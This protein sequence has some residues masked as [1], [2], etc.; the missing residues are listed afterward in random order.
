MIANVNRPKG[1]SPLKPQA[2]NPMRQD[3][4]GR[5]KLT[6]ENISIL[7]GMAGKVE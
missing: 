2:L 4:D 1:K 7:K 6:K 3:G 5:H